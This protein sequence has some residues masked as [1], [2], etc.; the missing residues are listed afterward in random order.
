MRIVSTPSE[1]ARPAPPH[2]PPTVSASRRSLVASNM[3]SWSRAARAAGSSEAELRGRPRAAGQRWSASSGGKLVYVADVAR[4]RSS[5]GRPSRRRPADAEAISHKLMVR[6]GLIRQ[7]G[8][9]LWTYLPAGWRAHRKVEAI[10]RDEMD[11]IGAQEMLM[12]VLQ[13]AEL[14]K[15][16]RPLRD[17]RAVQARGPQGLGDGA[18]DD[19]R[20]GAHLPRRPRG[21][22]LPRPAADPLPHPDQGAR[23]AAAARRR[24]AHARVRDEGRLHLRP[25]RGG[26]ASAATSCTSRP[27]TGSSTAAGCA[28]T[29]SSPTSG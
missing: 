27:T 15:R 9:G 26:P 10:I 21:P 12:P 16:D 25:R 7:L 14:W 17:R 1:A 3:V 22:L 8:A 4:F 6:A 23:R 5:S 19:P 2:A 29:G 18:G 24:A 20:G 11:A 13:P 28:G